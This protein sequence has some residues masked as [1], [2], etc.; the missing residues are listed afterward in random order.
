MKTCLCLT[1][2]AA[3]VALFTLASRAELLVYDG[4]P[5]GAGGYTAGDLKPSGT[6]TA[7][8][9]VHASI[10]GETG[11]WNSTDANGNAAGSGTIKASTT[12]NLVYP[13]GVN[14]ASIGGAVY[15]THT[16]GAPV[17]NPYRP[18][19]RTVSPSGAV[20]Q[21][22]FFA[23][24]LMAYDDLGAYPEDMFGGW[25]LSMARP[26][27]KSFPLSDGVHVGFRKA[28][29]GVDAVLC[30]GGAFHVIEQ[31]VGTETHFFAMRF[32]YSDTGAEIISAALL[33]DGAEPSLSGNGWGVTVTNEVLSMNQRFDW[34]TVGYYYPIG[35]KNMYVDEWRVGTEWHDVAGETAGLSYAVNTGVSFGDIAVTGM[36]TKVG[37]PATVARVYYGRTDG[38]D[39]PAAWEECHEFQ[40]P[41]LADGQEFSA[42]LANLVAETNYF[43]RFAASTAAGE[44]FAPWTDSFTTLSSIMAAFSE[45]AASSVANSSATIS[46]MMTD[47]YPAFHVTACLDTTDHG[48][49]SVPE[50]WA[51]AMD[52]GPHESAG[53]FAAA[54]TGLIANTDYVA[55]FYATND[56]GT[57]WSDAVSF[58]T[59]APTLSISDQY[60]KKGGA[61][62]VTSASIPAT[63]D[64]ASG[65]PVSFRWHTAQATEARCENAVPG[66]HYVDEAGSLTLPPG[67]TQTNITVRII[68]NNA[69]EFPGRRFY[70][71]FDSV[72]GTANTPGP[73]EVGTLCDN[74]GP[75][76]FDADFTANA[77]GWVSNIS[78][79]SVGGGRYNCTQES[80]NSRGGPVEMK[81]YGFRVMTMA[82]SVYNN[83]YQGWGIGV[84]NRQAEGGGI[85]Y[86]FR[87]NNSTGATPTAGKLMTNGVEVAS[88]GTM[89]GARLGWSTTMRPA[90]MRVSKTV[91]GHNRIQCWAGYY[92]AFDYIDASGDFLDGGQV[93]L[94]NHGWYAVSFDDV[95][96]FRDARR[97]TIF[98]V[99]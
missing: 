38:M 1:I 31:N 10:V 28:A 79:W 87:F 90:A 21:K 65:R 62:V 7:Q 94:S 32:E 14:L 68:G 55:R 39:D 77:A 70:I 84:Y 43:F 26:A 33:A 80:K 16:A 98:L 86:R 76:I 69:V 46:G 9:P 96:V 41:A 73:V 75:R 20:S 57:V 47:G 61:G 18:M 22:S 81:E 63:L 11:A 95:E 36:V 45:P 74:M 53:S 92:K 60:L 15:M 88:V 52:M 27:I 97:K 12:T 35:G 67:V 99:R 56:N 44:T 42:A 72:T 24:V 83:D 93:T 82:R 5:T 78:G 85:G 2:T 48:T 37:D 23:S 89:T 40:E 19:G 8:N 71:M 34:V 6:G 51:A 59:A 13:V 54:F 30:A 50:D 17:T 66:E 25:G 91:E 4:I 58:T 64:V 29:G 3:S 49:E